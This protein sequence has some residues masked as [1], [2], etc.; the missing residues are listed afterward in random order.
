MT[1]LVLA[2][3]WVVTAQIIAFLPSRDSHWRAAYF[4]IA[5]GL[6]ILWYVWKEQGAF[7]AAL[8]LVAAMSILRYPVLY[9]YRWVRRVLSK[10]V[11]D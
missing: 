8:V 1:S 10:P 5:A 2:G 6:P 3:L 11:G 9:L 7:V 4:L